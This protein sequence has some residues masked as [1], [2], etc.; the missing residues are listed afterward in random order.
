[1]IDHHLRDNGMNFILAHLEHLTELVMRKRVVLR[2]EG[3]K[4]GTQSSLLDLLGEQGPDFQTS[5]L[6]GN[7][8]PHF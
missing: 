6:A 8:V 3:Q 7:E 4:V 2:R 5:A 1:M